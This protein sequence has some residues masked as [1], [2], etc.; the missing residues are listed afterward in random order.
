M[1]ELGRHRP[2]IPLMPTRPVS[3]EIKGKSIHRK[4]KQSMREAA[5]YDALATRIKL[6]EGWTDEV[7]SMVDWEA[8]RRACNHQHLKRVHMIKLCHG[9]LPVG[10]LVHKCNSKCPHQ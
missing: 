1:E 9:Y 2:M 4:F 7:F 10:Q 8:H 5:S 3:L 6:R